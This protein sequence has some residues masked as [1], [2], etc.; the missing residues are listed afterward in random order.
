MSDRVASLSSPGPPSA[1]P[2]PTKT[3]RHRQRPPP[4]AFPARDPL[5]SAAAPAQSPPTPAAAQ[6]RRAGKKTPSSTLL[7][8]TP[9]GPTPGCE[10]YYRGSPKPLPPCCQRWPP[11]HQAWSRLP[12]SF[13]G[14]QQPPRP[15]LPHPQE[16]Q[17]PSEL[18][19]HL[20]H[21]PEPSWGCLRLPRSPQASSTTPPR[22]P[23]T[24]NVLPL[25]GMTPRASLPRV[26]SLL[27]AA[28]APSSSPASTHFTHHPPT[29]PPIHPSLAPSIYPPIHLP[30][31]SSTP[32]SIHFSI[33]PSMP[34]SIPPSTQT[35]R[36][37]LAKKI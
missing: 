26:T 8:P 23:C 36:L 12:A 15:P 9:M 1:L 5:T 25:P 33:H 10:S 19:P 27:G 22:S 24:H 37:Y 35:V 31:H 18:C 17:G 29:H 6:R 16:P 30:I 13:K 34:P 14:P 11:G 7:N 21:C 3:T 32:L 20:P 4:H 28:G 2:H